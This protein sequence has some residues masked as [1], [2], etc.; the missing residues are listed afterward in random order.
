MRYRWLGFSFVVICFIVPAKG[1]L[2]L[3]PAVCRAPSA[4]APPQ[5]GPREGMLS[6]TEFLPKG[7]V[8]DGSVSYQAELQKAIDAAASAG[9]TLVFPRMVYRLDET[10]L[11]LRSHLTLWL[12]GA[13]FQLD[14]KCRKDGQAFAGDGVTDV[15]FLG[16]EIAGRNNVWPEGVNVRG[17]KITGKSRNIRI[18]A[19][20]LHGL[21][22]NGIGLFGT[23]GQPI[24]DVWVSDV[25][26]ENCCN[27]YGDYLS[28][29]PGPEKGS[30]REDQGLIA[31]Y[32]VE[33][34]VVRGCRLEK[35]RS[36]GTHFYRCRRGQFVHN[37]VYAAQMGGYFVETCEEVVGSD[38]LIRDNGSRGV[39]IERGSRNCTLKGNVVANSGREGLWAPQ[40]TGLV[41]SGNVFD[42]N[43]RK[44][45]G[46]KP[47]QV[48]NANITINED[49]SDL[50]KSATADYLITDNILYTTTSQVA[51][52][53]IDA[54]KS[55][56][57]VVRNNLLRG[58]NRRILIEGKNK[59]SVVVRDND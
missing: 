30:V 28:K 29:R 39:T 43:G 49:P 2:F 59:D 19:M 15:Q 25:V 45:N 40:C 42:R 26:V 11:R 46:P 31:C 16:G 37:K 34:F 44:A 17:I 4:Q 13:V 35:S 36:D 22:S 18:R 56:G 32:F 27:R 6:V 14:A 3:A 9:R 50:T 47:H 58:E 21:S 1:G 5:P 7:Y 10:G 48:W 24:R 52:M 33:D 53:R 55:K 8:T 23:A 41:V 57:I 54:A 12:E 20:H 38:N 51:T